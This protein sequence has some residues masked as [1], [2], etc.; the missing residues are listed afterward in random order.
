M[1]GH[2]LGRGSHEVGEPRRGAPA[3]PR[4]F[5]FLPERVFR[6]DAIFPFPFFPFRVAGGHELRGLQT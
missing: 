1:A 6:F 4:F 3:E 5:T 2:Y